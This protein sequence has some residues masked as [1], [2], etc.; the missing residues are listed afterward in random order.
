M[1]E[2]ERIFISFVEQ[3]H[4]L[5]QEMPKEFRELWFQGYQ[6]PI[7]KDYLFLQMERIY[8]DSSQKDFVELLTFEIADLDALLEW[9]ESY[10]GKPFVAVDPYQMFFDGI[11]EQGRGMYS[12]GVLQLGTMVFTPEL[13]IFINSHEKGIIVDFEDKPEVWYKYK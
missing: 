2:H 12:V 10:P 9:E 5:L 6:N 13:E 4:T 11:D 3:N 7:S 8:K 1:T